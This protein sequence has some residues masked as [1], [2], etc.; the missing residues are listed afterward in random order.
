MAVCNGKENLKLIKAALALYD[1]GWIPFPLLPD[2]NALAVDWDEWQ[3]QLSANCLRRYWRAHPDHGIGFV[4][5]QRRVD[6][7][8]LPAVS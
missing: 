2:S 8:S 1:I 3:A 4:Q 7:S 5:K 6:K